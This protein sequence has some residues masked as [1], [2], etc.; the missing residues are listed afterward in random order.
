MNHIRTVF[1]IAVMMLAFTGTIQAQHFNRVIATDYNECFT[2]VKDTLGNWVIEPKYTIIRFSSHGQFIVSA[3][4]QY[5]VV[6]SNGTVLIPMIY[7]EIGYPGGWS[8]QMKHAYY[9]VKLENKRGIVSSQNRVI[10]PIAYNTI[11]L[12][13]DT[14]FFALKG[15]R[16]WHLYHTDGSFRKVP[17]KTRIRPTPLAPNV[18]RVV[19]PRGVLK[20]RHGLIDDSANVIAPCKY[21]GIAKCDAADLLW[22][23]KKNKTGYC[24][25]A[26]RFVWP[27]IFTDEYDYEQY[28]LFEYVF[29]A[30]SHSF[31]HDTIGPALLNG[32]MGMISASGVTV[33][34][35]VYDH[36]RPYNGFPSRNSN[37]WVIEQ[38]GKSGLYETGKGWILEPQ[39][40][41]MY[42][43]GAY[44]AES[45]SAF[46]GLLVLKKNGLF[47]AQTTSGQEIVPCVFNDVTSSVTGWIFHNRDSAVSMDITGNDLGVQLIKTAHPQVYHGYSDYHLDRNR[48]ITAVPENRMF[49]VF[50]THTGVTIFY[51]PKHTHDTLFYSDTTYVF[52]GGT[53]LLPACPD[54]ILVASAVVVSTLKPQKEIR[55]GVDYYRVDQRLTN[56]R[57]YKSAFV[58]YKDR[59]SGPDLDFVYQAATDGVHTYYQAGSEVVFR[60][61]GKFLCE[62]NEFLSARI[63]QANDSSS[64]HFVVRDKHDSYAIIDTTGN[65][66]VPFQE[67]QIGAFNEKYAWISDRKESNSKAHWKLIENRTGKVVYGKKNSPSR[68]LPMWGDFVHEHDL[69]RGVRLYNVARQK[70]LTAQGFNSVQGLSD[71]GTV[72]MVRT[73][74]GKLG[75]INSEGQFPV[76]TIWRY[77]TPVQ[78][79][80]GRYE[81]ERMSSYDQ[82]QNYFHYFIFYNDTGS[83]IFDVLLEKTVNDTALKEWIWKRTFRTSDS[84]GYTTGDRVSHPARR[85]RSFFHATPGQPYLVI[86][87]NDTTRFDPWHKACLYDS[88]FER[89]RLTSEYSYWLGDSHEFSC[90]YCSNEDGTKRYYPL[91]NNES[92]G[93]AYTIRA[94]DDSVLSFNSTGMYGQMMWFTNVFLYPDGPR[95]MT[96]DSLF[97][98]ASDWRN[99]IINQVIT[100]V[101]THL[102]VEGDCHNPAAFPSML[103]NRFLVTPEGLQLFPKDFRE[104]LHELVITVPWKDVDPYLRQDMRSKLPTGIQ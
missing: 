29:L 59:Q 79:T 42:P 63:L 13:Q 71:S 95:S 55:P 86:G 78:V 94:I 66:V 26:A 19:K 43:A 23:H 15:K 38:N 6:D 20:S 64:I 36:I 7:D 75:V 14:T 99:F 77:Y 33:L 32:K 88:I 4:S 85:G 74:S 54:S 81:I 3:R 49:N 68:A 16:T 65:V 45:D 30:P 50:D 9:S 56:L 58:I 44:Y 5:G 98:P 80:G 47:G 53:T 62:P 92:E 83:V 93:F 89:K 60:E 67:T 69:K 103:N 12:T 91:P 27:M 82:D 87:S 72:F 25:T 57:S 46:V 28:D 8:P 21:D 84:L 17:W 22:M 10:V 11:F 70:Y 76:D 40:E 34:P 96:L 37:V 73:C 31:M 100:Y 104:S 24:N 2:G 51:H 102:Y 39:L 1:F 90:A 48:T 41:Q 18:Y 97:D 35:F 101:N 61:D 52:S